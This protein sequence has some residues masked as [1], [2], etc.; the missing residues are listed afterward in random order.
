MVESRCTVVRGGRWWGVTRDEHRRYI[1]GKASGCRRIGE[2]IERTLRSSEV[3]QT[4]RQRR[5]K[6]AVTYEEHRRGVTPGWDQRGYQYSVATVSPPLH[7]FSPTLHPENFCSF[8][9]VSYT[10][11]TAELCA[12]V[13]RASITIDG[14]RPV[15]TSSQIR[16]RLC[17]PGAIMENGTH[18]LVFWNTHTPFFRTHTL[19]FSKTQH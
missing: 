6:G 15:V 19:F 3:W 12:C 14:P 5:P 13:A 2:L 9:R 16:P 7:L 17:G 4:R 11:G 18:T 10:A 1:S 8:A